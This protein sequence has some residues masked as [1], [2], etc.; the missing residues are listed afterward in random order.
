MNSENS[1]R[2]YEIEKRRET[3]K[4]N[5]QLT[6][7]IVHV[8]FSFPSPDMDSIISNI[9][10]LTSTIN[11]DLKSFAFLFLPSSPDWVLSSVQIMRIMDKHS[12]SS[13]SHIQWFWSYL[14]SMRRANGSLYFQEKIIKSNCGAILIYASFAEILLN[15]TLESTIGGHFLNIDGKFVGL[16]ILV[17]VFFYIALVFFTTALKLELAA[18]LLGDPRGHKWGLWVQEGGHKCVQVS[19]SGHKWVQVG[20]SG[21]KWVLASLV[22]PRESWRVL[23]GPGGSWRVLAG[24]GGHT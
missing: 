18:R 19:I 17:G 11:F 10:S 6:T 5:P 14:S 21:S 8:H 24:P 22:A 13:P 12:S 23:A 20:P 3:E 7:P 16:S 15:V 9:Y 2:K 4:K 1:V